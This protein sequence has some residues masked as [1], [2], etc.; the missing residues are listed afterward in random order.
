MSAALELR[1]LS[2]MHR[3]ARCPARPGDLLGSDPD[4]DVVLA[5]DGVPPRAARLDLDAGAWSLA[6][7]DA[8]NGAGG[9]RAPF[10]QPL[11]L[12]P[13]WITVAHPEDPWAE[14]ADAPG[15][16]Q[17][18]AGGQADDPVAD[19]HAA[20]GTAAAC[21]S[22]ADGPLSPMQAD[23]RPAPRATLVPRR[24]SWIMTLGLS[25]AALAIIVALALAWLLPSAAQRPA[26]VDRAT[27]A[28]Q[29]LPQIRTVLERLGLAGRLH[30][31]M[32]AQGTVQVS[33]WVRDET[34]RDALAAALAQIWPMPAM[35]VST[36]TGALRTAQKALDGFQV[37]YQPRYDG[38]G[39]LSI[40]GVAADEASRAAA[41]EAVRAQLPG[42]A[43]MGN[44]IQLAPA[45]ADALARELAANGLNGV[46]LS[47]QPHRLQTDPSALDTA[48]MERFE[49]VLTAFNRRFFDI[50]ALPGPDRPYADSVPFG[51]RSVVGGE[52]P[53]I[54]L[55]DGSKLLVGGTYRHYRLTAIEDQ[56]LTFDGPRPAIVLR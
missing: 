53:F 46:T 51:I 27:A 54:V 9:P 20:D 10:G 14:P 45:V 6:P 44:T 52:T 40:L 11:P 8:Q 21:G 23:P 38:D 39:R 26:R 36:E 19:P 41:I 4:C 48:Q 34:E 17:A 29:S 37:K 3:E 1:V 42:M 49:T 28:Q 56:R 24:R 18:A 15:A 30:A 22:A 7:D 16:A 31:A 2:G 13:V 32:T 5:D 33:G 43:V 25:A 50:A 55:E 35:Q 47:W 12:G